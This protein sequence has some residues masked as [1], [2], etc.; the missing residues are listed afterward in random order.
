MKNQNAITF[1]ISVDML[2]G[3]SGRF[4]LLEPHLLFFG[5]G[6]CTSKL[7]DFT[8]VSVTEKSVGVNSE[9]ALHW[10]QEQLKR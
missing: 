2:T 3:F 8:I 10:Y 4:A 7:L 1:N 5:T 6:C 9:I